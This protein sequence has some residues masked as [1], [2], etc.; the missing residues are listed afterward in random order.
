MMVFRFDG[1]YSPTFAGGGRPWHPLSTP[2][3]GQFCGASRIGAPDTAR[4]TATKTG[5]ARFHDHNRPCPLDSS[6]T[7]IDRERASFETYPHQTSRIPGSPQLGRHQLFRRAENAAFVRPAPRS[8]ARRLAAGRL[9]FSAWPTRNKGRRLASMFRPWPRRLRV[10][11]SSIK[12]GRSGEGIRN[13]QVGLPTIVSQ[14][15]PHDFEPR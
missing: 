6:L 9:R 5:L 15:V 13:W 14:T 4:Q 12:R 3:H 1:G 2:L 11:S 10:E 7:R 8:G